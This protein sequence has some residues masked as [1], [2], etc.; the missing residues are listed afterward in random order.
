MR[1]KFI[2]GKKYGG[3]FMVGRDQLYEMLWSQVHETS[4]QPSITNINQGVHAL[5]R[6]KHCEKLGSAQTRYREGG[7]RPIQIDALL[8]HFAT[9]C[10]VSRVF[11]L[12]EEKGQRANQ[13]QPLLHPLPR[14]TATTTS[15][16]CVTS[17][18]KGP[19]DDE[20]K[21]SEE[22]LA[23]MNIGM[24]FIKKLKVRNAFEI[25]SFDSLY[26][27][28]VIVKAFNILLFRMLQA[29]GLVEPPST[30]GRTSSHIPAQRSPIRAYS[31]TA[32]ARAASIFWTR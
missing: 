1:D 3:G 4:R 2:G 19:L 32:S 9:S 25:G 30:H 8:D 29:L 18:L 14:R 7:T 26:P 10:E 31:S 27:P 16:R 11:G 13:G 15:S 6:S 5:I 23:L 17:W 21:L 20:D 24:K 22:R 28:P 12:Q